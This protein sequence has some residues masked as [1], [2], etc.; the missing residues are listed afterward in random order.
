MNGQFPFNK[1][2]G[3]ML[4]PNMFQGLVS[5]DRQSSG[6]LVTPCASSSC[7]CLLL[8]FVFIAFDLIGYCVAFEAL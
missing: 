1:S 8:L 5:H 4:I 7:V 2:I 6:G 3:D